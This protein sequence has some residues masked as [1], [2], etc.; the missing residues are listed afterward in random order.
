MHTLDCITS[1]PNSFP[2]SV[3]KAGKETAP[4]FP[5]PPLVGGMDGRQSVQLCIPILINSFTP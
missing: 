3:R 2:K 1:F 4:S 5:I